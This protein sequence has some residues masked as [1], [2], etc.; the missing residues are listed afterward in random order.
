MYIP[1]RG[2]AHFIIVGEQYC[3]EQSMYGCNNMIKRLSNDEK[4]TK[5]LR[6]LR[7]NRRL[8]HAK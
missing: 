4:G 2:K 1:W 7:V 5:S 8:S 6:N 3:N